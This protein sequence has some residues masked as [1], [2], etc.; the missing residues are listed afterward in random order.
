MAGMLSQVLSIGETVEE[1]NDSGFLGPTPT[2]RCQLLADDSILQVTPLLHPSP[3]LSSSHP[4]QL[5]HGLASACCQIQVVSGM[6]RM[7]QALFCNL[8]V[9]PVSL[10]SGSRGPICVT[11]VKA[12][13]L[14]D[15]TASKLCPW[16]S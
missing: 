11:E 4:L 12:Q 7:A 5:T 6:L 1:V 13:R 8:D 10:Q 16:V 14:T 3:C 15:L 9:M 2:L